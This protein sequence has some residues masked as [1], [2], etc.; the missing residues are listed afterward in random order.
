MMIKSTQHQKV[1]LAIIDLT[2]NY[3]EVIEKL[4]QTV[5]FACCHH[6]VLQLVTFYDI[7]NI[8]NLNKSYENLIEKRKNS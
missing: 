1:V 6:I 4:L 5:V 8:S 3:N 7:S 2:Q